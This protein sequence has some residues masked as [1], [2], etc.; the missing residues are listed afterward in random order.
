MI[1]EGSLLGAAIHEGVSFPVGKV[2]TMEIHP[3]SYH[4]FLL[5]MGEESLAEL[6]KEKAYTTIRTFADR[7]IHWLKLYYYI[8]GMPE[9]VN[10]YAEN[11]DRTSVREIQKQIL[12]LYEQDFSRHTPDTELARLRMVWNSVPLQLAKEKQKIPALLCGKNV[13][14]GLPRGGLDG[15]SAAV[16]DRESVDLIR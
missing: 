7:Y 6:L 3:M 11:G 14:G 9:A 8:G 1:T 16:C 2:E 15:E 4:E 10:D 5:A 13:Y 12:K